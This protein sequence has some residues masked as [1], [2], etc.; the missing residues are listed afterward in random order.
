MTYPNDPRKPAANDWHPAD[1]VAA[2]RKAGW[3]VTQLS[4]QHGYASNCLADALRK[5]YPKAEGII[6]ATLGLRPEQ[7]WPSRYTDG[8]PNRARGRP[9]RPAG[10]PLPPARNGTPAPVASDMQ[11]RKVA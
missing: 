4:L 6:A 2:L 7:I 10:V 11:A 1:V 9:I 3:S 5:P 8:V